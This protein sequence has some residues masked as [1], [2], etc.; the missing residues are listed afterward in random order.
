MRKRQTGPRKAQ[1][2]KLCAWCRGEGVGY[3]A[4]RAQEWLPELVVDAA[5]GEGA[6]V[7]SAVYPVE[8]SALRDAIAPGAKALWVVVVPLTGVALTLRVRSAKDQAGSVVLNPLASKVESRSLSLLKPQVAATLRGFERRFGEGRAQL[9]IDQVWPAE[10]TDVIWRIR[11]TFPEECGGQDSAGE[12]RPQSHRHPSLRVF[13]D[14]AHELPAHVVVMEDQL[15][16]NE[17]VRAGMTRL[18][19]FSCRLPESARSFYAVAGAGAQETFD[20]MN[21]PRAAAMLD[22]MRAL[23]QQRNNDAR[24][25]QWFEE[26][27]AT[28]A[29]L[30]LQRR[31]CARRFGEER[32]T[33]GLVVLA[34][35]SLDGL[36]D[37]LGSIRVQTYDRWRACVV[38]LSPLHEQACAIIT[39]DAGLDERLQVVRAHNDSRA[40]SMGQGLVS[41][42][43][44]YAGVVAC[45][46]TL[47]PDALWH[48][49]AELAGTEAAEAAY[50]DEDHM[51]GGRFCNPSFKT[52]PNYGRLYGLNYVGRL[53]LVARRVI[54][55]IDLPNKQVEGAEEY[56]LAL[57]ALECARRV[58]HVPH[59]LYHRK[60][61][62]SDASFQ[63]G[64]HALEEHLRRRGI[65]ARVVAGA[66]EGTYRVRFGLPH[67]APLVSI[68]IPTRDQSSLLK[69]C[70]DSVL[71]KTTY[72]AYEVV[73]VENN[74]RESKTFALY[75]ELCAK[76]ERVRVVTWEPPEPGAFNYSAIVNYGVAQCAGEYVVLLNNDT[77]V[78]EPH[79]LEE[80]A[81][82]LMRPE[83]GVVGAK[84]LFGDGLIQ[85]VGMV[86]NPEGNFCHVCQNLTS[87][88]PGPDGRALLPGDLSMVTGACQMVR[89]T[90]FQELGGY[91]EELAVGY[92]DGDFCLRARQAGYSVTV[93]PY[94]LL[95]H[96]EFSTR[97]RERTDV[98]L[99]ERFLAERAR[100]MQKHADFFSQG[101]PAMNPNLDPFGSYFE[102]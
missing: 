94:A 63:A 28:P 12:R 89:R 33:I 3:A 21:A 4:I 74:S 37:S 100:M 99:R 8:S 79:W 40:S 73:L 51:D 18:V 92:N 90:V 87:E 56:D 78:I 52:F 32:P 76:G 44:D 83:V 59:V 55:A 101:D 43:G 39:R 77:E 50:C 38:C 82:C 9:S 88:A 69:A 102:L 48:F 31:T 24:Y 68:V 65:D 30:R 97:G 27:R 71:Q 22:G 25:A 86:A 66:L 67:P 41:V 96:R 20:G 7:P 26:H 53:L 16:P 81:G 2:V 93:A 46:D 84:L 85:H 11:A 17:R 98:R 70:V 45:G 95:H 75:N 6:W 72:P 49:A 91:D 64:E 80:M 19:T 36:A 14:Q 60:D 5:S 54:E 58:V 62:P 15:V 57:K 47:E 10:G 29:E 23:T 13:D 42:E 61:D 1:G 34:M 35:D